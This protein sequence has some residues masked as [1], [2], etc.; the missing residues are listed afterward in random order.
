MHF[1]YLAISV[2]YAIMAWVA[3]QKFF[4]SDVGIFEFVMVTSFLSLSVCYFLVWL[5]KAAH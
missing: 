1:E 3:M 5:G 4:G 2:A